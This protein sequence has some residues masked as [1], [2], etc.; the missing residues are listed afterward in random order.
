MNVPD[1]RAQISSFLKET[2]DPRPPLLVLLGPT[3]SGKTALSVPL[4]QEFG[5]EVISADS[6]QVYRK[7]DVGT[8]KI[9]PK[10]QAG[11]PHHL[12]DVAEPDERF[13]LF[14]YKRAAEKATK[15]ITERGRLPFLVGGTG[16]Y[17]KALTENFD[18]PPEDAK[19]REELMAEL[20]EVGNEAL[21]DRLRSVDPESAELIHRNNVPYLIRALEIVKLTGKPKSELKKPSPYRLLKIGITRPREELYRRINERVDRQIEE[22][23]LVRETQELLDAGYG[24]DL[25]SMQSL[26]YKEIADHLI[27]P[28][29]LLEARELL[30]QNTRHFAKRQL[31]WWRRASESDVQWFDRFD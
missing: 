15:E 20:E 18:L 6:R 13:T 7:M 4:A 24:V 14:E 22:G 1:I 9:M 11:V 30:K 3:A 5:A 23:G 29:T 16:L 21:H 26:G 31:T 28:L 25:P 27:G 10:E 17:I 8:D 2:S 19:L 12:L